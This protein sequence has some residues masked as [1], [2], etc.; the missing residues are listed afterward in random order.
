MDFPPGLGHSGRNSKGKGRA[1]PMPA[2]QPPRFRR[3]PGALGL[4]RVMR[5]CFERIEDPVRARM[6]SLA[7]NLMAAPAM[8]KYP[9]ILSFDS[10]VR[11]SSRHATLIRNLRNFHGLRHVPCNSP[12]VSGCQ[13]NRTWSF[14]LAPMMMF[15][16]SSRSIRTCGALL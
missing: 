14:P 8:F 7:D 9:S 3:H 4:I 12:S 11:G 10:A 5:E 16:P 2:M 6:A 13:C 1:V 15:M